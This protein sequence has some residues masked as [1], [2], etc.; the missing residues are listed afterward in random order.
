[1]NSLLNVYY[2]QANDL[3]V[4]E[5]INQLNQIQVKL[6]QVLNNCRTL[7]LPYEHVR[8]TLER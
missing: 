1:M 6:D 2:F 3:D 8:A 7:A 5:T 4:M